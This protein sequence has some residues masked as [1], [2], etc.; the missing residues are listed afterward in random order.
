[1]HVPAAEVRIENAGPTIHVE[2]TPVEVRSEVTVTPEVRVK[3]PTR[4]AVTDVTYDDQGRA[5]QTV[6]TETDADD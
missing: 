4:T 3:L 6:R 2:P 1:V 5:T